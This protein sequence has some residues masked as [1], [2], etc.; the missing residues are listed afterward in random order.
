MSYM[1]KQAV[2]P[3]S[4]A[5]IGGKILG[6]GAKALG[7]GKTVAGGAKLGTIA[8]GALKAAPYAMMAGSMLSGGGGGG[9]PG[10][11]MNAGGGGITP[12]HSTFRYGG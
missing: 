4:A 2:E 1:I 3:I 8:S 5:I 10:G 7:I 6:L 11:T 9:M 12:V